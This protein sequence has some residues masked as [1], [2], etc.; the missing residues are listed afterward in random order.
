MSAILHNAIY[1][2]IALGILITVHEFGHFW[3]AR[4]VGVRVLR[5]SIGFGRPLFTWGGDGA[6]TT[7]YVLAAIPLGGY[8]K[9]LDEREGDVAAGD[10][11]L[12]FNTQTLWKRSAIV[13]A[14]PLFNLAFA[15]LVYWA[16]LMAGESGLKP[17]I[18]EVDADSPAERAGLLVGD[19]FLAI[20]GEETLS[21][22]DALLAFMK[23]SLNERDLALRVR[24]A[25]GTE[26]VRWLP[27]EELQGIDE[28]ADPL[29][30]LGLSPAMPRLP[31][32]IGEVVSGEVADQ[33]GLR[34]GDLIVA[35]DGRAVETWSE[36]VDLVEANPG[37]ELKVA[38]QRDGSEATLSLIPSQREKGDSMVG[39]IGAGAAVP[40]GFGDDFYVT[41]RLG[42]L[43][44]FTG[45]VQRT[46]DMSVLILRMIW[47]LVTLRASIDNLSGPIMIAETAG[48]TASYGMVHFAQFLAIV[49]ISL[50]V[51][52]LLPIPVL[53]GGHLAFFL[54]E[55]LKGSPL[56]EE[57]QIQGQKI[58]LAILAALM[59]LVF[60]VDISRLMG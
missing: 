37:R 55:G 5:F 40:E 26:L 44:A 53:D 43:D 31:P 1:F 39:R 46:A 38:Y 32:K 52:N 21:W 28:D 3:V 33:A 51:L 16:V 22:R 10:R 29:G 2:I 18:G 58:G 60:Y 50:G 35:V 48:R 49:S 42:P 7:E 11:H 6:T 41:V 54:I 14:G 9:M 17:L 57:A 59:T 23:G 15:V 13:A 45:A 34:A 30:N 36:L 47:R 25:G 20:G 27:A 12:A 4:K 24:E 56:S 19:E 8:V